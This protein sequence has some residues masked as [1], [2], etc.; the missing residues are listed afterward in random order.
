MDQNNNKEKIQN[1]PSTKENQHDI[2]VDQ[3]L[4]QEKCFNKTSGI[5]LIKH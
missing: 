1:N 2:N 5:N 3:L 4:E